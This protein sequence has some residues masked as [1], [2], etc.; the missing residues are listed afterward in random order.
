VGVRKVKLKNAEH[1]D[2]IDKQFRQKDEGR[3]RL[4]GGSEWRKTMSHD[5]RDDTIS[6]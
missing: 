6:T 5:H 2:A 1:E 3:T 4:P